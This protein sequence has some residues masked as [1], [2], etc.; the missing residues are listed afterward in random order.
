MGGAPDEIGGGAAIL[1]APPE[2]F[3]PEDVRGKPVLAVIACYV[4][5]VEAGRGALAPRPRRGGAP[6]ERGPAP[7]PGGARP[8]P[9]PR[10]PRP[11]PPPNEG[12][13]SGGAG[14]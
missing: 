9:P 4:G 10:P 3:V 8:G 14:E 11:P 13:V 5:P 12:G 2:E 1:C 7:R 6:P